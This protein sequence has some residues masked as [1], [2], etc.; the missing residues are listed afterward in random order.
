[1]KGRQL[2]EAQ[3]GRLPSPATKLWSGAACATDDVT[4]KSCL[5]LSDVDWRLFKHR[6]LVPICGYAISDRSRAL[7]QVWI[8]ILPTIPRVGAAFSEKTKSLFVYFTEPK[9]PS[10]LESQSCYL[11]IPSSADSTVNLSFLASISLTDSESACARQ[12]HVSVLLR[13]LHLLF[14]LESFLAQLVCGVVFLLV[15]KGP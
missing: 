12:Q 5:P 6:E 14:T 2:G 4:Q 10:K 1:M 13:H 3:K 9:E 15:W 11:T 8:I 7:L